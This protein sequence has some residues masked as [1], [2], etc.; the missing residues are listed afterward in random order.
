MARIQGQ[1]A[2]VW[3]KTGTL[4]EKRGH[5]TPA[6]GLRPCRPMDSSSRIAGPQ[7]DAQGAG[8]LCKLAQFEHS[9][10]FRNRYHPVGQGRAHNFPART[11]AEWPLY[12]F[13]S[14]RGSGGRCGS[15]PFHF[16][17]QLPHSVALTAKNGVSF[18]RVKVLSFVRLTIP[19]PHEARQSS[20]FT[21]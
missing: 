6:E 3:L 10:S 9:G 16:H 19:P 11:I 1:N 17:R 4:T 21:L 8:I 7:R 20:L 14:H 5:R 18:L 13:T 12:Y 2:G 15:E